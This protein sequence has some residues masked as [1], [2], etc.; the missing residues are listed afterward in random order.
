MTAT[1][2]RLPTVPLPAVRVSASVAVAAAGAAWLAL[3]LVRHVAPIAVLVL[4]VAAVGVGAAVTL[5]RM[6]LVGLGVAVSG[7]AMAAV[8]VPHAAL[9]AAERGVWW[10]LLTVL[11]GLAI[12]NAVRWFS[13]AVL[14]AVTFTGLAVGWAV[15]VAADWGAAVPG[16]LSVLLL[17]PLARR[18]AVI[19]GLT[20]FGR[21]AT[22]ALSIRDAHREMLPSVVVV[23][24]SAAAAGVLLSRGGPFSVLLAVLLAVILLSRSRT[25][26]LVTETLVVLAGGG[27][28]AAALVT[29]WVADDPA[30]WPLGAALAFA[31]CAVAVIGLALPPTQRERDGVR[32]AVDLAEVVA[33]VGCVPVAIA[34]LVAEAGGWS[35]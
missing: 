5:T 20:A 3:H 10:A 25:Q 7:A 8:T 11:A 33:L 21:P 1:A 32:R 28:V 31:V 27:V 26:A 35:S 17:G 24:V 2:I 14:G 16:V 4:G 15:M 13:A 30:S 22:A 12:G 23:S 9:S 6:R 29:R 19:A 34:A 18:A